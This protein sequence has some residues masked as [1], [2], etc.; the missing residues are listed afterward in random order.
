M[1]KLAWQ[2]ADLYLIYQSFPRETDEETNNRMMMTMKTNNRINNRMTTKTT[3]T[4]IRLFDET[5]RK[6]ND[7]NNSYEY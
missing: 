5:L 6:S 1:L 3:A 4:N 2:K 7:E